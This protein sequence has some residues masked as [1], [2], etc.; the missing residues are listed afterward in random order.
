MF[1][2]QHKMLH[3]GYQMY[4]GGSYPVAGPYLRIAAAYA[5]GNT[6]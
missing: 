3:Q 5:E 4:P 6:L 1:I 2:I